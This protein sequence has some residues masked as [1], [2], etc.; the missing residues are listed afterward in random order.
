M[1]GLECQ[2]K[3][4]WSHLSLS[5]EPSHSSMEQ[6]E[7]E[8]Q[9]ASEE[10]GAKVRQVEAETT[11]YREEGKTSPRRCPRCTTTP[12]ALTAA[13]R[14]DPH[15]LGLIIGRQACPSQERWSCQ[16]GKR[17]SQGQIPAP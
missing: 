15:F 13:G 14:T 17:R 7:R 11:I 1:E 2:D 16:E 9:E 12:V 3:K 5:K 4:L 10:P 6:V 8:A